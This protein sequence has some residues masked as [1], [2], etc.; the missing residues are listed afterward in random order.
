MVEQKSH[1]KGCVSCFCNGLEV[2]CASS[3]Q[4]YGKLM[5]KFE[6][7]DEEWKISDRFIETK[8]EMETIDGGIEFTRFNEFKDLDMFILVPNKF[9]GN[10]VNNS[11]LER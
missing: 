3:T 11:L 10:M 5:A 1:K 9:K 7:D 8:L 2:D 6:G 4:R